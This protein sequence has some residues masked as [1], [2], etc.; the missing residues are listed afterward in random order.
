MNCWSTLSTAGRRH[1]HHAGDR[2][3]GPTREAS[4][5]D[6]RQ[7][8]GDGP[9]VVGRPPRGGVGEVDAADLAPPDH[10][11]DEH[12]Q[13]EHGVDEGDGVVPPDCGLEHAEGN[14]GRRDRGQVRQAAEQEGDERP[15]QDAETECGG[16]GEVEDAAAQ[17]HGRERQRPGDRPHEG[18]EARH[19]H[20]QQCGPVGAVGAGPDRRAGVAVAEEDGD[21]HDDDRRHHEPEQ[22][23]GV[24]RDRADLAGGVERRSDAPGHQVEVPEAGEQNGGADQH[25]AEADGGDGDQQARRVREPPDDNALGRRPEHQR[26]QQ[27]DDERHHV[28][29]PRLV[30]EEERQDRGRQPQ[31]GLGE[32]D[33]P[34]GPVDQRHAQREQG[35]EPADDEPADHDAR[36]GR[37]QDLLRRHDGDGRAVGPEYGRPCGAARHS[38]HDA[39]RPPEPRSS[40][41]AAP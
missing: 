17:E 30:D 9:D 31:V 38:A 34:V 10:H 11:G 2:E 32:V 20:A 36:R 37:E 29:Q 13:A 15:Q 27:T 40:Y 1:R 25:L 41:V 7:G 18:L 16:G 8:P 24:E 33:D 5:G 19:R 14:R 22:V 3:H 21:R 6:R 12:D 4:A 28:G 35:R 39:H 26:S 23:V